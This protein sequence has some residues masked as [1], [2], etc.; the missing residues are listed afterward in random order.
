LNG[1]LESRGSRLDSLKV[2]VAALIASATLAAFY[3][4]ADV[5]L[6][7]RVVGILAGAAVAA[8]VALQTD[9]GRRL[10]DFM[11]EARNEVRRVVWPSRKETLQTTTAV[12]ATVLVV[13]VLLWVFDALLIWMVR[14]VTGRGG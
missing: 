7:V 4:Y 2:A 1:K 9:A 11:I 10:R 14:L 3:Y 12:I 6:A 13:A 8:A 5:P